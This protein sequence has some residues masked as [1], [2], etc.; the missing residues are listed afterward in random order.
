LKGAG[1]AD[2]ELL[3]RI[4]LW[5]SFA[6]LPLTLEEL[7]EAVAIEPCLRHLDEVEESQVNNPKDLLSLGGS[8]LSISKTGHVRLAHLS[9]KDY[10]LSECIQATPSVSR[11]AM[12]REEANRELAI[13]CITYLFFG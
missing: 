11:F 4:L 12:S 10:L 7:H 1:E 5:V 3:R 9:V 6:V 2:F 8:L 13:N